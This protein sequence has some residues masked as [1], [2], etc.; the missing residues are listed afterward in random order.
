MQLAIGDHSIP[1]LPNPAWSLTG[2]DALERAFDAHHAMV[3][4]TA[5]RVTGNAADAE[6]V[7]QTVFL[8]LAGRDA[9][10]ETVD[11]VEGYLHRAAV[12]ASLHLLEQR[13]RKDVPLENARG[14]AL[15]TRFGMADAGDLGDVLR[16][17]IARLAGRPAEM[18]ALR[19]LEGYSNSDI[20]EMFGVSSLVVAV[21]LH[22][23][24]K[25]LQKEIRELGG[26]R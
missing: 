13:S 24:R 4:R 21:T 8:R 26:L 18:F 20:A 15:T 5:Y 12:N 16:R 7:L 25:Q 19:F 6:D 2:P 9:G 23:A 14:A 1:S 17:A 11:N 3:F 22:R 10:A